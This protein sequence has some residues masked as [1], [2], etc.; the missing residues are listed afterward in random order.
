MCEME[1]GAG[2]LE[3][4]PPFLYN[5]PG[6]EIIMIGAATTPFPYKHGKQHL[7]SA[8]PG[9]NNISIGISNS[10]SNRIG[11]LGPDEHSISYPCLINDHTVRCS[12][13]PPLSIE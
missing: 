6:P 1:R 11:C 12:I 5:N 2:L 9:G 7:E 10:K 4:N 8:Q 3:T 13:S